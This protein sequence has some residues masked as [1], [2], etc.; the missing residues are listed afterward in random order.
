M[1]TGK[2]IEVFAAGTRNPWGIC[3]HSNGNIYATD[4]GPN[5]SYG[6]FLTGCEGQFRPDFT[7]G[8]KINLLRKGKYYGTPNR[9][10]ALTDKD[11]RQCVWRS[12][13]DPADSNYTAPI[14]ITKSSTD[15]LI[16]F[17]GDHFDRQLRG[18]LIA[19]KYQGSLY[20]VVLTP[21]GEGVIPQSNPYIELTEDVDALDVTQA[22]N[23]ILISTSLDRNAIYFHKP[24]EQPTTQLKVL[25]VFPR[26]GGQGGGNRLQIYGENFT[27][28]TRITVGRRNCPVMSFSATKIECTL[29]GGT[30]T[31]DI[32]VLGVNNQ[33]Y[34][35]ERGYRYV[36]GLPVR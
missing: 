30:G 5:Y 10:R 26:R 29:P 9:I 33:K 28:M 35:F 36:T 23:G 6:D 17:F 34:V 20:R 1:I 12:Q 8:D 19:A 15:G 14:L 4:N 2:G 18:N 32:V 24:I 22:P 27:D 3:L 7:E 31:V 25:S 21:D 13:F 16:E 11:P